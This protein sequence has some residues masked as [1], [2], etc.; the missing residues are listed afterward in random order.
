MIRFSPS[1]KL[2]FLLTSLSLSRSAMGE[3][4]PE[5]F[6]RWMRLPVSTLE[7][8][9][10]DDMK[11]RQSTDTALVC[12][13]IITG[14]Y[15]EKMDREEKRRVAEAYMSLWSIY[16]Y[17]YYD[18]QKCFDCLTRARSIAA[19]ARLEIPNIFLGFGC[20]YQTITEENG[21]PS[22]AHKALSYYRMAYASASRIHDDEHIDMAFTNVISMANEYGRL[23]DIAKEWQVYRR[24]PTNNATAILRRYNRVLYYSAESTNRKDFKAAIAGLDG[25]LREIEASEYI[26]L[27]YF[28]YILKAKLLVKQSFYDEAIA[29]LERPKEIADSLEM[30]DC[31][32]EVYQLLASLYRVTGDTTRRR[33]F[34]EQYFALK[35]TLTNY[36]QLAS[37]QEM[38]FQ[39]KLNVVNGE[40]KKMKERHAFWNTV[41]IVVG[42]IVFV[43]LF[44]CLLLF[45][46]YRKILKSNRLLFQKNQ[47][48]LQAEEDTRQMRR[49]IAVRMTDSDKPETKYKNSTL[50][51]TDKNKL[52][53][54]I[55]NVMENS[56]EIFSPDF[57][58]EQLASMTQSKYKYVSQVIH[59]RYH[60][61][62][63]YFLNQY[64]VKEACKRLN[65][66]R[67]YGNK[68]IEAISE[69]VGFR[70]RTSFVNSFKRITGLTP[71][72]YQKIV[73]EN[74]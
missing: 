17:Q 53:A 41:Y 63:N 57:T 26:R 32:L 37:V 45:R 44:F 38:E 2:L 19:D 39:E 1:L 23:A 22:L 65:D 55:L 35:D 25:M 69:S 14:R 66:I 11:D 46:N 7:K 68:T 58:I 56:E 43:V 9:G 51:E 67:R 36:H 5:M 31:Q 64:R 18:Y 71:S 16:F 34:Q 72:E 15:D 27:V 30:K 28:T 8:M 12:Y 13:T 48:L 42:I 24:L 60:C 61:N 49:R 47:E 70:S 4:Q 74:N 29:M 6:S 20:M 33:I 50:D 52:V 3:N 54:S 40:M 59:E 73:K 62:F 10:R 21:N